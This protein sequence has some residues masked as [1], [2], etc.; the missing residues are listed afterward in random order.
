MRLQGK[1]EAAV[2]LGDLLAER[3]W[4]QRNGGLT[5]LGRGKQ[6]KR[7]RIEPFD[8]PKRLPPVEPQRCERIGA[9]K[10]IE[11]AFRDPGPSRFGDRAEG[12]RP[13]LNQNLR[14]FL[15]QPLRLAKPEPERDTPRP[16]PPPPWGLRGCPPQLPPGGRGLKK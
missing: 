13:G 11:R 14:L 3:R 5:V 1:S 2:I 15:C 9:G 6:R 7:R 10:R 8:G 12:L 4:R 16:Y